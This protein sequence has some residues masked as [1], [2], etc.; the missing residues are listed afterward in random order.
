MK[1]QIGNWIVYLSRRT[2][3][4]LF[5]ALSVATGWV[6]CILFVFIMPF[7][8]LSWVVGT[9]ALS[10]WGAFTIVVCKTADLHSFC[11]SIPRTRKA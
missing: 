1:T 6:A 7:L 10:I 11:G 5:T 8:M 4:L 2:L 3:F 9:L